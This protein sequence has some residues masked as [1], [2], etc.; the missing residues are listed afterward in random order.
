MWRAPFTKNISVAKTT[1]NNIFLDFVMEKRS[2]ID[3][4]SLNP[5]PPKKVKKGDDA[6]TLVTTFTEIFQCP[7]THGLMIDP[8]IAEDGNTYEREAIE[9][10]LSKKA[11]SPLNPSKRMRINRLIPARQIQISIGK[12]IE[13]GNVDEEL[14]EVWKERKKEADLIKAQ[15]LY[16]E[17]S[18]MDAAKLGLP[19]AQ[20]KVAERYLFGIN[21]VEKDEDKS[22]EYLKKGAEGGEMFGQ[23]WLANAYI[24][25]GETDRDISNAMLW[26]EKAAQQGCSKSMRE[27]G[28]IYE[29]GGSDLDHNYV[30]K[31]TTW[32][33]KSANAGDYDAQY[34]IG[35]FY[36]N[37]NGVVKNHKEAR[38][39]FEKASQGNMNPI[40]FKG[41]AE[42]WLGKMMMKGEGGCTDINNG[43]QFITKS[44][45]S[46]CKLAADKMKQIL[47]VV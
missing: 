46:G 34:K 3:D 36:Y 42:F 32:Y 11:T 1:I 20:I 39:W 40:H 38:K 30:Q 33:E 14:S 22:I 23:Y 37:G 6:V 9:E 31:A 27:L 18:I 28:R 17:G 45:S 16:D 12:M 19:K 44:A 5:K 25:N 24:M 13:S 21:K 7:I 2:Q 8:V 35:E 10:W 41:Y 43:I 4:P 15:K 29:A 47:E 26:F